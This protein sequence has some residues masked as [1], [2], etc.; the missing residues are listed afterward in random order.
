MLMTS[1]GHPWNALFPQF[2]IS[3]K[4]NTLHIR[5]RKRTVLNPFTFAGITI[6]VN[7]MQFSNHPD[8]IILIFECNPK[9]IDSWP[10]FENALGSISSTDDGISREIRLLLPSNAP[11]I[12]RVS[13]AFGRNMLTTLKLGRWNFS[14]FDVVE[15]EENKQTWRQN[16]EEDIHFFQRISWQLSQ[17]EKSER[18]RKM[19]EDK[20]EF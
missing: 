12:I 17:P 5:I 8:E 19:Q 9:L 1:R 13:W 18:C 6:D 2:R 14:Q 20:S 4:R 16:G 10:A 3:N 15:K 7:F 11:P